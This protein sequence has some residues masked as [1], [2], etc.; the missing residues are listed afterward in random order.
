MIN[1]RFQ[2]KGNKVWL[3]YTSKETLKM[4]YLSFLEFKSIM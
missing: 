2:F 1:Y 4:K 3:L